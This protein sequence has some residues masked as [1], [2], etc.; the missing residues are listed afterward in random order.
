M[1]SLKSSLARMHGPVSVHLQSKRDITVHLQMES[2]IASQEHLEY[3]TEHAASET[4]VSETPVSETPRRSDTWKKNGE[5]V[6][7]V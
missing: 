5:G 1:V 2:D 4:P 3:F 6:E 7:K